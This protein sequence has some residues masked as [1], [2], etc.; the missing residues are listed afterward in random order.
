MAQCVCVCVCVCVRSLCRDGTVH[1]FSYRANTQTK[2]KQS[3]FFEVS[4][5]HRL[6][7][8]AAVRNFPLFTI[9]P[10]TRGTI[11]WT[12]YKKRAD[13]GSDTYIDKGKITYFYKS[14]DVS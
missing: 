9:P 1:V 10:G 5:Q 11:F 4:W 7:Q 3:V 13:N 2:G 14:T 12:I 6:P 8:T